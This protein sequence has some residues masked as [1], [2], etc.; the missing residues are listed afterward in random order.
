[1][2]CVRIRS[3]L[4]AVALCLVVLLVPSEMVGAA[5]PQDAAAMRLPVISIDALEGQQWSLDQVA[6]APGQRLVVTN[7]DVNRHNFTVPEWGIALELLT[8]APVEFIIPEDASPGSTVRFGSTRG[9]DRE[10]G[11]EGT[12]IIVPPDQ[13]LA[14]ADQQKTASAAVANRETLMIDDSFTFQPAELHLAPG[15]LL[16][17]RNNGSIEHHFVVDAWNLNE[18]IGPGKTRLVQIPAD[19]IVGDALE[20]YC[21][22]PGHAELGM[23]G[24][25]TIVAPEQG[26]GKLDAS[27]IGGPRPD[28][29]LR[30]FLPD[31]GV[32][33]ADWLQLRSGNASSII[34]R[35]PDINQKVF[36]GDGLGAA[37]VGPAG[38]RVTIVV[39]PLRTDA[40][41]VNQVQAAVQ[42]I[43]LAMMETWSTDRLSST[44]MQQMPPPEG[45]DVA[46]RTSGIVP[47]LTLPAGSTVC[48]L[49]NAGV[50]IFVTVE[51]EIDGVSGVEA[52]DALIVRVLT[53]ELAPVAVEE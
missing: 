25:V 43:Q 34:S 51:G 26:V 52:A 11:M 28:L 39:M 41:P 17:V 20:F 14:A 19:A 50:A 48:E 15:S 36:P 49:R 1:M 32:V 10:K 45:C 13:I 18:T 35:R 42:S 21:S 47:V 7:R 9:D 6:A 37:Y 33:G 24:A 31:P 4:M 8:L 22:V 5:Q 12:I 30:A 53:R 3:K 44:A 40:V 16:E 29:D 46:L 27:P 2:T 23:N 38:S